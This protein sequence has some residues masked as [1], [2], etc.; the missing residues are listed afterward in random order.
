ME[1]VALYLLKSAAWLAGF[2]LL[3][4]LFL[5]KERF[6]MLKRI[7]LLSGVVL[8]LLLPLV[9]LHYRVEL[10]APLMQETQ[11]LTPVLSLPPAAA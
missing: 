7:Y 6:F 3:Y 9:T 4:L 11:G 8:S 10:P 5:R 2:T 1:Q